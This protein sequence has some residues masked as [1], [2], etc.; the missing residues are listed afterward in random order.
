VDPV[1]DPLLRKN[2]AAPGIEPGPL[3]LNSTLFDE[4]FIKFPSMQ[5]ILLIAVRLPKNS[6]EREPKELGTTKG[7]KAGN[8][9][10]KLGEER[11]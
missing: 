3:D 6:V 5:D 4:K 11:L 9:Q 7:R 8:V 2:L 1:P 10:N